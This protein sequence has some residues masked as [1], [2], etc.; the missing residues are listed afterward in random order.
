MNDECLKRVINLK[1]QLEKLG[2]TFTKNVK[3]A[4]FICKTAT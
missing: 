1:T 4:V 2:K 3:A